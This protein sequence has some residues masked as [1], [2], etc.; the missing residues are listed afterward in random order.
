M[1]QNENAQLFLNAQRLRGGVLLAI[2]GALIGAIGSV[3]AG[4]EL[5][6]ATR[7]WLN[8]SGYQP[9]EVARTRA[10]QALHA[11]QAARHAAMEA[12][13]HEGNN[14]GAGVGRSRS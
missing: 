5:A 7:K 11:S 9:S 2:V 1:A 12:W 13:Q 8:E 14:V 10:I 6:A 4:I 3:V